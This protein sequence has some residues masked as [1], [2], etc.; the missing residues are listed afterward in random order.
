ME[1]MITSVSD[2]DFGAVTIPATTAVPGTS[3][4]ASDVLY[5]PSPS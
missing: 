3:P 1:K 4:A 2:A 5:R